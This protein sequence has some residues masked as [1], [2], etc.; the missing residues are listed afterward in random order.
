MRYPVQPFFIDSEGHKTEAGHG[1]YLSPSDFEALKAEAF[2]SI[3]ER[4]ELQP[5]ASADR[6]PTTLE[7][8]DPWGHTL[9]ELSKP[10]E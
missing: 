1:F 9:F 6:R 3:W 5:E 7:I 10:I 4:P 8:T 2:A